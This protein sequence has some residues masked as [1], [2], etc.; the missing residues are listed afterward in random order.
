MTVTIN[1][2][3]R[4]INRKLASNN[5]YSKVAVEFPAEKRIVYMLEPEIRALQIVA[6]DI[7]K[8]E[9]KEAFD[10]F[11]SQFIIYNGKT[12]RGSKPMFLKPDG[13]F[14]SDFK[15]GFYNICDNLAIELFSEE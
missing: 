15:P 5:Y 9:G 3:K 6:R 10:V 8:S 2:V 14:L 1:S 13:H 4:A 11:T 12:K 7:Y